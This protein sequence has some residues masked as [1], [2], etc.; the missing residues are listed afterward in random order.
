VRIPERAVP[1]L[2]RRDNIGRIFHNCCTLVP[3]A[4]GSPVMQDRYR[5]GLILV[6]LLAIGLALLCLL[7]PHAQSSQGADWLA[8][9]PILFAG[10][11]SLLSLLTESA[12]EYSGRALD[13][14]ALPTLFQ[15]PPPFLVA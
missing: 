6:A 4:K 8:I 10:V 1:A 14:P 3:E 9:L 2:T 7:I 13:A 11:I 12:H 15:R 5:R